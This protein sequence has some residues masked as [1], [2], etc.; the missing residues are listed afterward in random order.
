MPAIRRRR[1]E[2]GEVGHVVGEEKEC[3][4]AVRSFVHSVVSKMERALKPAWWND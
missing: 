3:E 1:G 4:I 2:P